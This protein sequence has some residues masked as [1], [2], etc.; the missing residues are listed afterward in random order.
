MDIGIEKAI[1][2]GF[3]RLSKR[4]RWLELIAKPGGRKKL[5]A[6]LAHFRDL[7]P[8]V[9][10]QIPLHQQ[11]AS[12]IQCLLVDEGAP[13]SCYLISENSELDGKQMDL[14]LD[15]ALKSVVGYGFGTL[16]SCKPGLLGLKCANN[17]FGSDFNDLR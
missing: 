3:I 10:M 17:P 6:S 9:V 7:D 5:R 11:H 1:I 2:A 14:D 16:I 13:S 8:D 4:D 12:S 15:L